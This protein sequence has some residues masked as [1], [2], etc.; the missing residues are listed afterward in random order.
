[1]ERKI[2]WNLTDEECKEI[3]D[4]YEKKNAYENLAKIVDADNEKMYQKLI[5]DY[6]ATVSMFNKWWNHYSE[7][8]K[9]EGKNWV[10]DFENKQV[11]GN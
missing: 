1:M 2:I 11:L 7:K 4:L 5:A 10:I 9:W 6:S 8:Y 3:E